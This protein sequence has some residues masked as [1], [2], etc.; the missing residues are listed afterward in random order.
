M[1]KKT[2]TK[3]HIPKSMK[4]LLDTF[5]TFIKSDTKLRVSINTQ[6][7]FTLFITESFWLVNHLG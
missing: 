1:K 2:K 3:K 6:Y 5:K 7:Y 4:C